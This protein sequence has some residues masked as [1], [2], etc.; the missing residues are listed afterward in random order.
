MSCSVMV[1]SYNI[2]IMYGLFDINLNDS[3]HPNESYYYL[4]ELIVNFQC[5]NF[6]TYVS[7][8]SLVNLQYVLFVLT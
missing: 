6:S 3:T 1:A 5:C 2:I 4:D 7:S 8:Q